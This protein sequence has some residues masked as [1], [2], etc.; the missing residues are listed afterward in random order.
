MLLDQ[1]LPAKGL[2]RLQCSYGLA[3]G[4]TCVRLTS[5]CSAFSVL[6]SDFS[7]LIHAPFP[8]FKR[9]LW[10]NRYL[11]LI[12]ARAVTIERWRLRALM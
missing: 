6:L 11:T 9:T 2:I 8:F 3:E 5:W 7:V 12:S 10:L 4:R 1:S